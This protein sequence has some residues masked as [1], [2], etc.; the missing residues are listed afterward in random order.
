MVD[1]NCPQ[2]I[3]NVIKDDFTWMIEDIEQHNQLIKKK[4]HQAIDEDDFE[5]HEELRQQYVNIKTLMNKIEDIKNEY[6][7]L[8]EEDSIENEESET[9]KRDLADWTDINPTEIKLFE[10]FYKVKSWREVL[11][12]IVE[13]LIKR[14]PS[15]VAQLDKINDFKGRTRLY[16]SYNEEA[17]NPKFYNKATNGLYYLVN[18]SA[19]SIMTLCRK[20]LRIGEYEESDLQIVDYKNTSEKDLECVDIEQ[21]NESIIKLRP[22]YASISIN[23]QIFKAIIKSI[24]DRKQD[25]GKDYINPREIEYRYEE[26]ILNT[27]KYT[28]AYPVVINIIKYLKDLKMLDHFP[29]TKK[30]KYI[31]VSDETLKQWL[32]SNI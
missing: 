13:E 15:Y 9:Y 19:N 31:V 17:I 7:S 8:F 23:K 26:Q 11:T 27:T 32:E 20:V 10:N 28:T 21:D 24:I 3:Y 5:E 1:R 4:M 12:L 18:S 22:Q 29:G 16:F 2:D 6:I 30:G 14:N 25:Y